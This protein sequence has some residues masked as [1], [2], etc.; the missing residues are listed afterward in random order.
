MSTILEE[1]KFLRTLTDLSEIER[2]N[3]CE[4]LRLAA[5]RLFYERGMPDAAETIRDLE[6]DLNVDLSQ[7]TDGNQQ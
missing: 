2:Q 1:A 4:T 5:M 6:V 3:G 7:A